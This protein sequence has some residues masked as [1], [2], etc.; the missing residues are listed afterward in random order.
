M[1]LVK[2]EKEEKQAGR[3]KKEGSKYFMELF[4]CETM[5]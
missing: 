3:L 4:S 5:F 1:C 2:M